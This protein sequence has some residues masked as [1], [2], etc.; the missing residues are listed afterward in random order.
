MLTF[1]QFSCNHFY[2]DSNCEEVTLG[3][4]FCSYKNFAS[5]IGCRSVC[6]LLRYFHC[7]YDDFLFIRKCRFAPTC[8][9]GQVLVICFEG[10]LS[11]LNS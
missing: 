4:H 5:Y 8:L 9:F 1:K 3:I 11:L 7:F 6:F 2:F 10:E